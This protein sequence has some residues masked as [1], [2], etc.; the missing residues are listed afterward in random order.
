MWKW[1]Y[2]RI[3]SFIS[4]ILFLPLFFSLHF[5]RISFFKTSFWF[6]LTFEWFFFNHKNEIYLF[7]RLSRQPMK[8]LQRRCWTNHRQKRQL[9]CNYRLLWK[10]LDKFWHYEI[11]LLNTVQLWT[12]WKKPNPNSWKKK[13]SHVISF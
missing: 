3:Q 12:S 9:P 13:L 7:Y 1:W 11:L 4:K 2:W 6:S 5:D 10:L 8:P